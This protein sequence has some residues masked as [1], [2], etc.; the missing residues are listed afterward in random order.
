VAWYYMNED[1]V[2]WKFFPE[3]TLPKGN[4]FMWIETFAL[5]MRKKD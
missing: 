5:G 3:E 4:V 1:Q 2:F